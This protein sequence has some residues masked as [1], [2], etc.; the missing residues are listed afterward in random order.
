MYMS[1]FLKNNKTCPIGCV[2]PTVLVT[3]AFKKGV[4]DLTWGL[5]CWAELV[6]LRHVSWCY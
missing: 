4:L 5:F 1:N 6:G 3:Y 2:G